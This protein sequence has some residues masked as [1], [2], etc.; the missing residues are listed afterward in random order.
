MRISNMAGAE[1]V[2]KRTQPVTLAQTGVSPEI[3]NM[4]VRHIT[5][6]ELEEPETG[7]LYQRIG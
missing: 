6:D 5:E 4:M 7:E 1:I 2:P 3:L